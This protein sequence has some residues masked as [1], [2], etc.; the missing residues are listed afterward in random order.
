MPRPRKKK[1]KIYFGTPAQDAI[2]EYNGCDDPKERS[3]IYEEGIKFPFEKL[4]ENVLN[5]FRFSYFDVSKKDIQ[6][7]VVST[8]VEKIHMFK[9][10]KGRAFSYF[11]IIAKNHLIL[12]NNG[13]YK[14][15]KQ[16]S[17]LS[18]MPE[19]W[20]PENDF[21]EAEENDEFKEFKKIMLKFWDKN[22]NVIFNKKR[23]LQI[24][25]AILELFRRSEHIENFNKKHLYLLI[26]EMTD[27]KT[28]YITKVVNVMKT[29]QKQMLN[30][31][32]EY[33]EFTEN[34]NNGFWQ[35]P[36][37]VVEPKENPFIDNEY[38]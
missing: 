4:A 16:N 21:F 14:R 35:K 12:K 30:Q 25:D 10:G 8:M 22:L 19:T 5:T 11:T 36:T 33:G 26:R 6:T 27:C 31:Y 18:A 20:N 2:I 34:R 29:H 9:P 1:S 37:D 3:K 17:L 28:H 13:N 7:E 32:L 15:W 23:D 24:A 38:L